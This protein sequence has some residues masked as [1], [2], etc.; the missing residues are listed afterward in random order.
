MSKI[1][2]KII[3]ELS[4]FRQSI[5]R[6]IMKGCFAHCGKKITFFPIGS[7][8]NYK[9]ISIGE[10]VYIGPR[11]FMLAHLSHI[12][13][14]RNTAIGPNCTIIGGNHRFDIVGKPINCY[15]DA[16]K[17]PQDDVDV[18]IG[19]DVWLGCNVTVL[20]GVN[21]GRGC[22]VAAGAVVN[23]SLPPYSIAGGVPAKVIKQRFSPEEII[24]HEA[25]MDNKK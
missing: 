3:I 23:K 10:N 4:N 11:A 17:R 22:I 15:K 14:G 25:L 6:R 7:Y 16:D 19:E 9:K 12:Y 24:E 8:F 2:G 20:S 13:I 1:F 5:M 18:Y 21:I